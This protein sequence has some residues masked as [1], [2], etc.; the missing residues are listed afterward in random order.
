MIRKEYIQPMAE[1]VRL[2]VSDNITEDNL[3]VG[4]NTVD[5][6]E[7]EG[8]ENIFEDEGDGGWHGFTSWSASNSF[9]DFDKKRIGSF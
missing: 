7:I 5:S 4:S 2:N 8:K 1:I 6:S 9:D 3:P